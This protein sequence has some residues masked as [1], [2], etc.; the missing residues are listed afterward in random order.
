MIIL[1]GA[2]RFGASYHMPVVARACVH[3]DMGALVQDEINSGLGKFIDGDLL[4]A[5]L[6]ALPGDDSQSHGICTDGTPSLVYQ[7]SL[8]MLDTSWR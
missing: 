6:K 8:G 3:A 5:A 4:A 1:F 7:F 2:C